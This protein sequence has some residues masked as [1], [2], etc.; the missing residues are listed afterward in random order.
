[1]ER[2]YFDIPAI[3]TPSIEVHGLEVGVAGDQYPKKIIRCIK[4]VSV[5]GGEGGGLD[6]TIYCRL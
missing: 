4:N 1:M 5:V 2:E 6:A 3:Y